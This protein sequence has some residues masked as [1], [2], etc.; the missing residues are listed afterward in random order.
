MDCKLSVER[1]LIDVEQRQCPAH[2]LLGAAERVAIESCEQRRDVERGRGCYRQ[3][4][5]AGSWHK[6]REHVARQAEALAWS[7]RLHRAA[8]KHLRRRLDGQL[9]LAR[10]RE[11]FGSGDG[12][13]HGARSE[14]NGRDRYSDC[15]ALLR[16]EV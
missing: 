10:E 7:K 2:D 16:L 5:P 15:T 9:V 14:A 6:V 1:E 11:A 3:R 13:T 12:E 4:D 8:R